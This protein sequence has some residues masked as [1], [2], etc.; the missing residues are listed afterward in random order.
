M[1]QT[2]IEELFK[3]IL[4][5]MLSSC[6]GLEREFKHK[7]AGLRTHLLVGVGSTLFTLTALFLQQEFEGRVPMDPS[8]LITGVVTGIGFLCA[9]AIMRAGSSVHGL[10]TAA[11]LWV[12]S[13]IGIAVG[14][15]HYS[16]AV[17]TTVTVIVILIAVLQLEKLI[18]NKMSDKN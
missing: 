16:A 9:G 13:G 8:R 7:G 15:G 1:D 10:T 17:L 18:Y 11:S 5:L 14:C 12:V 2:V 6:I 3:I 4:S